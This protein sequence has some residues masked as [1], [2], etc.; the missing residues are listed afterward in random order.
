MSLEVK[1][2]IGERMFPIELNDKRFSTFPRKHIF[3]S[4]ETLFL[5][6]PS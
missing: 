5:V 6:F 4:R 2:T 3:F 1:L